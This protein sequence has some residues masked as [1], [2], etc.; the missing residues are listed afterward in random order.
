MSS[1]PNPTSSILPGWGSLLPHPAETPP[2]DACPLVDTISSLARQRICSFLP[3]S[4][5][6]LSLRL[7]CRTN[8][9]DALSSLL[10]RFGIPPPDNANKEPFCERVTTILH[11]L[12]NSP[13]PNPKE[14]T[15][16]APLSAE[17]L[18]ANPNGLYPV[19]DA[20]YKSSLVTLF[21]HKAPFQKNTSLKDKVACVREYI[22]D[23]NE[24]ITSLNCERI[25]CFPEELC[26]CLPRLKGL[27]LSYNQLSHLPPCLWQL[28][29][30]RILVLSFSRISYL[31]H[32]LG[33]LTALQTLD[34]SNNQIKALPNSFGLLTALQFLNLSNNQIRALPNSCGL[35]TALQTLNLSNNQ[36]R[37]LPNSFG[38]LAA[39]RHLDLS[40]NQI[41]D[42]PDSFGLLAA[43]LRSLNLEGNPLQPLP[44]HLQKFM[45]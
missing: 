31:P 35:L 41:R 42:L 23:N 13:A 6:L 39:L 26:D 9:G 43:A 2:Q 12:A 10:D 44:D 36:I 38:L 15:F 37:V 7:T 16:F 33:Q 20:A 30:L 5:D 32:S 19:L 22:R 25:T 24:T 11:A 28:T 3:S 4:E 8:K 21:L 14:R 27:K 18:F 1:I 45:E 40:N 29:A 34:L 17:S